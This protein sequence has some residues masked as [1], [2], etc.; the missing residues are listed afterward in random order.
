MEDNNL[1]A[2]FEYSKNI[3]NPYR[4]LVNLCVYLKG[5]G[6]VFIGEKDKIANFEYVQILN[7]V[8]ESINTLDCFSSK[9]LTKE[10]LI[11]HYKHP[12]KLYY[13]K[14]KEYESLISGNDNNMLNIS[15][16]TSET[17]EKM[18][19]IIFEIIVK[20]I[21]DCFEN[22]KLNYKEQLNINLRNLSSID[23]KS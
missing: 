1:S 4:S 12:E 2:I 8:M 13:S 18:Q 16:E 11:K 7:L 10:N 23:L 9:F 17:T 6:V 3:N 15:N 22:Q 21:H 19:K 14:I 5:K 20:T